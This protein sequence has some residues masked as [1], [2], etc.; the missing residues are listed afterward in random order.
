M[1]FEINR[2][3][4]F[5]HSGFQQLH[6]FLWHGRL[7][8]FLAKFKI[9]VLALRVA[10]VYDYHDHLIRSEGEILNSRRDM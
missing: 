2:V 8:G 5:N 1:N 9:S 4:F 7:Q 6:D 10:T 3:L